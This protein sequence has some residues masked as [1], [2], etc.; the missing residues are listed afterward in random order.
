MSRVLL[1]STVLAT[2]LAVALPAVAQP[3]PAPG[4]PK[5][6]AAARVVTLQ[7]NDAMKFQPAAIEARPGETLKV[8]LKA[9]GT[10]PK[11]AM[12]HNFILLTLGS[13][14]ASFVSEASKARETDFVPASRKADVLAATRLIGNGETAEVTFTVPKKPGVYTF[15]CT[16][17]GHFAGGMKGTLTVK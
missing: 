17:P 11:I 1:T 14:A 10:F 9:A 15:I 5:A 2:V 3:T 8:V 16:F 6:G 4:G 13:D 7:A 12:A